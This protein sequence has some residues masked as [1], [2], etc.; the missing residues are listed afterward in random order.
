[1]TSD[2]RQR[3]VQGTYSNT[4]ASRLDANYTPGIF[5]LHELRYEP[6]PCDLQSI[7]IFCATPTTTPTPSLPPGRI[8]QAPYEADRLSNLRAVKLQYGP[9][10]QNLDYCMRRRRL[11]EVIDYVAPGT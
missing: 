2:I 5:T 11:R 4:Y 7:V 1:M 9:L 6:C 10:K 3:T 8:H